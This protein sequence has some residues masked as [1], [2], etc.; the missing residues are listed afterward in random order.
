MIRIAVLL[1]CFN[2]RQTTLRCLQTLF[3]AAVP[4]NAALDVYLVDDASPDDTSEAVRK[5]FPQVKLIR[6]TGALYWGGGTRLA[7]AEAIKTGYD[8]Y[9]W[10]NDD[11]VLQDDALCKLVDTYRAV[12]GNGQRPA[13]VVGA[14]YDPETGVTT[15]GGRKRTSWHPLRF[16]KV[17]PDIKKAIPCETMN[18][19]V[20]LIPAAVVS[21]VGNIEAR[22]THQMGDTDYG[23]RASR[24]GVNIWLCP[25]FVGSCKLNT[26][27]YSWKDPSHSLFERMRIV[28]TPVGLPYREYLFYAYRH[29]GV[30][31]IL[32]GLAGYR[33]MI[34]P[35]LSKK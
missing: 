31:G 8:F 6:G 18:G 10:L 32:L 16:A 15:Y 19:N 3:A 20:V 12:S 4:Q 7:F 26:K 22:F 34:F 14:T 28:N 30:L 5:S 35:R 21:I 33:G 13:I 27:K 29:G 9:L 24:A 25:G 17:I 23:L 11:V 2:R 1:T